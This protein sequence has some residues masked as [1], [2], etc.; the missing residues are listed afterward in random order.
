MR[1]PPQSALHPAA[2]GA[3]DA[4]GLGDLLYAVLGVV[5]LLVIVLLVVAVRHRGL[6]DERWWLVGG[7]IVLPVLV[8]G[9]LV[10]R[11][12]AVTHHQHAG[13]PP[14]ALRIEVTG[15]Q[16]WWE[17]RYPAVGGGD[18]GVVLANEI[19]LPAGAAVV[20]ELRTADVIHGFW[21]PAL[22]GKVD[23]V[24]GRVTR[25]VVRE[26][27]VGAYRGQCAE[28]C[29][30]QHAWMALDVVVEHPP[31]F[32]RWLAAQARPA[33]LPDAPLERRGA[34]QF[35]AAGCGE[36]HAVRGTPAAGSTGPDLTHVGSRLS[37]G[38]G[39]LANQPAHLAGWIAGSQDLK[40]GNEMPSPPSAT[41]DGAGLRAVVAYLE[42]LQ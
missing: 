12:L 22:G 38:A 21:V 41:L 40:P 36:C 23:M 28:F 8:L 32:D 30:L 39:R 37:I 27:R 29:G 19:R 16:W 9:L 3:V 42:S 14:G 15:H 25:L 4:A 35:L 2:A 13:A 6:P 1:E 26:P 18:D 34:R 17:V 7:G 33:N 5:L 24:P 11:S 31:D 20:L 10:G